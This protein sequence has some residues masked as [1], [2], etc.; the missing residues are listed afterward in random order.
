MIYLFEPLE[1]PGFVMTLA[2]ITLG[3]GIGYQL[4]HDGWETGGKYPEFID[5]NDRAVFVRKPK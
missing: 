1:R 2:H 4:R 5:F 3:L